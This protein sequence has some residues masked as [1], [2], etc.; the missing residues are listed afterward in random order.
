[1]VFLV[2]CS[3]I[4]FFERKLELEKKFGLERE[5]L[6]CDFFCGLGILG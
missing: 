2:D 4:E 3:V 6:L 1:M 5:G